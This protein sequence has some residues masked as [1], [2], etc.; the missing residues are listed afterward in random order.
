[1]IIKINKD[2]IFNYKHS[3]IIISEI[4]SNH[5][6]SKQKFLRLIEKSFESGADLVKIQTYEPQDITFKN[7]NSKIKEG[8]WKNKN[9]W[10]LYEKAHTPFEWHYDAFKIAKKKKKILFSTPFSIRSLNFLKQFKPQL[11]KISSFE[12]TDLNLVSEIAKT[13]KPIILSSGASYMHEVEQAIKIIKKFHNKIILLHCVSKY[14][15]DLKDANLGRLK[16][17]KKKYKKTLIGLSDHTSDNKT[18]LCATSLGVVA[19]EKHVKLNDKSVTEDSKFSISL[20]N[21]E[22]LKEETKAIHFSLNNVSNKIN[23]EKSRIYRRSI[24]ALRD[25]KRGEKINKKNIHT[26]RPMVGIPA[27]KFFKIIGK[28]TNI[29]LKKN[30]PIFLD[31]LN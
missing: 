6:G 25:I 26:L 1:M 14:P 28:K 3:P 22:K 20:K 19:I 31:M 17:L 13:K 7:P 5:G 27:N 30:D 16:Y 15:T 18:S 24:F 12:I 21:L 4:S 23:D 10:E 2:I 29:N 11:Y 9:L 8:L